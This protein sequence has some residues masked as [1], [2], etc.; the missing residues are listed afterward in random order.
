MSIDSWVH[1]ISDTTNIPI[2]PAVIVQ[3]R[4]YGF[5]KDFLIDCG[6]CYNIIN[7]RMIQ[8]MNIQHLIEQCDLQL[9]TINNQ[10]LPIQGGIKLP[11]IFKN[12]LHITVW[13][14]EICHNQFWAELAWIGISEIGRNAC[15]KIIFL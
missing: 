6:A 11:A 3:S 5:E 15:C 13:V 14:M 4:I 10:N 8:D 7:S 9:E 2:S 12:K 1:H